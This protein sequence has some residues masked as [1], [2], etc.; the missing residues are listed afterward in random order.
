MLVDSYHAHNFLHRG[1]VPGEHNYHCYTGLRRGLG[2]LET[3]GCEVREWI[4]GPITADRLRDVQ[5]VVLNLPSMDRPPWLV[6][7]IEAIDAYVRRGGGM[8]FVTDHSNC[9]YHQYHLLPLWDRLGLIPS[10]ETVC[11]RSDQ[12]MLT[13]GSPAW[14]VARDFRPHPITAQ[15]RYWAMQTGGRVVGSPADILVWTSD[16][17]WADAGMS[18][19][20]GEGP[21]GLTGDMRYA[22]SE[23]SGP[24]GL[25]LAKTIGQGRVVVFTDQNALGDAVLAYAHNWRLWAN[26]CRWCGR[27]EWDQAQF[28]ASTFPIES[29]SSPAEP[30]ATAASAAA[31]ATRDAREASVANEASDGSQASSAQPALNST[32]E[33]IVGVE[34]DRNASPTA[35]SG[36]WSIHCW[37]PISRG[38]Y[39]FGGGSDAQFYNFW[40]WLNRWYW[41]SAD[42]APLRP[43]EMSSGRPMLWLVAADLD[44]PALCDLARS[45]LARRGKVL[46][47]PSEDLSNQGGSKESGP[48]AAETRAALA[49]ARQVAEGPLSIEQL[50]WHSEPIEHW[51]ARLAADQGTLVVIRTARPLRNAGFPRPDIA[52]DGRQLAWQSQFHRWLFELP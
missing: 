28:D 2:L 44:D 9:Y 50:R 48:T 37:E 19:L 47:L 31:S 21:V 49:I 20:Y 38:R 17:A 36:A 8:V 51:G 43:S 25:L 22:D 34:P 32:F 46:V 1:L 4:V 10:F 23:E 15:V 45:T 5:L 16:R 6:S 39:Y 26:A 42:D 33:G 41:T 14:L 3:R 11:E 40:C 13:P 7:E 18:P 27:L 35:P 29:A 12:R 24:Q 52:P 30:S